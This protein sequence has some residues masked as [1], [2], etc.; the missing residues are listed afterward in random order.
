V[1]ETSRKYNPHRNYR[2]LEE[3]QL[4]EQV[5]EVES[6]ASDVHA[7]AFI[8]RQQLPRVSFKR[9]SHL[10]ALVDFS[11]KYRQPAATSVSFISSAEQSFVVAISSISEQIGRLKCAKFRHYIQRRRQFFDSC[12]EAQKRHA[13][14]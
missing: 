5:F 11:D 2:K 6:E 7:S 3:L 4:P 14:S 1:F 9:Q 8:G 12:A 13:T 10:V